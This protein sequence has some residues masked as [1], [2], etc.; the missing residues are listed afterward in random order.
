MNERI[1]NGEKQGSQDSESSHSI[2][3]PKLE[4]PKG[5]GAIKGID[6]KFTVN[7][8]NGSSSFSIP[9][10]FSPAR[11]NF[12]PSLSASYNSGTGNSILGIGWSMETTSIQRKTD[13]QLPSYSEED[14]FMISGTEDL[15]PYFEWNGIKWMPVEET[16]GDFRIKRF[17]PRIEG[18]FSRI[19]KIIHPVIGTF[20]RTCN[21]NNTTTFFGY[22]KEARIHDPS[23]ETKI[24]QWLPEFSFDDKGNCIAFEYKKENTDKITNSLHEKN[25]LNGTALFLNCYLKRVRH[26]NRVPYYVDPLAPYSLNVGAGEFVFETVFDFGEHDPDFPLPGEIPAL[27]WDERPDAFSSY[28]SGFEIRTYRLLKRVLFYH[29]FDELNSGVSTLVRSVDFAYVLSSADAS[30]PTELSCLQSVTHCG[31][32]LK[33]DQ[34]Y[35]KKTLPPVEF[36]YEKLNWSNTVKELSQTSMENLPYGIGG[37]YQWMDFFGEGISGV[38]TEQ[39]NGWFYKSNL[40]DLEETGIVT[41]DRLQ[42]ISPKPS[43]SGMNSGTLV[44]QDIEAD[45]RKQIVI[46]NKD[47]N[48]YFELSEENEWGLFRNFETHL[49]IDLHDPNVRA[50]DLTGDGKPDLLITEHDVFTIHISKGKAGYSASHKTVKAFDEEK[51]P[52]IVFSDQK[53]SIY[54]ADLSGDGLTDIVRIRNGEVCYWPNLGYGKFGAKISM[55]NAPV[56]DH[57]DQF[58]PL[59]LQLADVSGTGATDILY[60]GQNKCCAYINLAGNAW[61]DEQN[62]SGAFRTALPDKITVVDLSGNGTACIVWSSELPGNVNAPLL[63]IDLMSGKKPHLMTRHINNLGKE[64]EIEY[65]SSTWFYLKDKSEQ[66]PWITKLP[67]PVHCVRKQKITDKITGITFTNSYRYHH[68]YYD[69]AEREFRGFGMV[70][71]T[72]TEEYEHWIKSGAGN[73]VPADLH[74][75]PVLTK[76]WFHTGAFLD[77]EKILTQFSRE[78]WYEEMIRKGFPVTSHEVMLPDAKLKAAVNLNPSILDSL[79]TQEWREAF[80]ACKGMILRQ[81]IFSLDAPVAGATPAQLQLELSPYSVTTH[82]CHI[83]LQQPLTTNRFAVFT[84]K[85]SE[86]ITY[87]YERDPSD[88]RIAHSL[89]IAFDEIGNVLEAASVVYPRKIADP[90]LPP[91]I[92]QKQQKTFITYSENIYTND[93]TDKHQYRLRQVSENKTYELKGVPKMKPLY[94]VNDFT[95]IVIAATELLYQQFNVDPAPGTSS[96]RLIKHLRNIFYTNDLSGALPL[97]TLESHA[98]PFETYQKAYTPELVSNIFGAKVNDALLL[99]GK[100]THSEG[101]LNWWIRSGTVQ[102]LNPSETET[103]ARNHFYMPVSF[104]EPFGGITK[105][106]YLFNYFMFIKETEDALLNKNSVVVFNF[107]TLSPQRIKDINNN[108]IEALSDELS[109]VK[110]TAFFG[111]GNEADDLSGHTEYSSPADEQIASDLF[112]AS[113]SDQLILNG[114]ALLK[115]ATGYF[116]YDMFRYKNSFGKL[117]TVMLSIVRE[118]HFVLNNDSP[119]QLSFEY[120]N[121]MGGV[122]MKKT[123]CEPGPAKNVIVNPDDTIVISDINTSLLVPKQLR[124]LGNGRTVLNNKGKPVKQYE[125]Y[126]S[127]T[128]EYED[129]KELVETGVTPVLYY[130]SAGRLIRT[131]FPN[132]TFSKTEF[133]SWK[134]LVFDPNDTILESSWYTNRINH[135][136]DAE[137]I[138]E[139]KDPVKEK[140]AAEQ[141]AL[142]ANTPTTQYFD[143]LG[144]PMFFV[145]H[146]GKDAQNNELLYYSRHETDIEGN[147]KSIIDARDN[148]VILYSHDMLSHIVYQESMDAGKRWLFQNILANPLRTWDQRNHEFI[149]YYDILHRCIGKRVMG[150]DSAIPL[151]HLIEKIIFGE[152]IPDAAQFN[153]RGKPVIIY[154]TAG[155]AETIAYDFKGNIL[156]STRT[157][158]EQYKEVVNWDSV[159]PD[160][161]L[162]LVSHNS[163]TSFDALGRIFSQNAAD[164]SVLTPKYNESGKLDSIEVTQGIVKE[165]F[166]KNITYNEKGQRK[167]IIYGNN[168]L[169]SYFYDKETFALI[170]LET[171]KQNNDPLQDFYYTFDPVGNITHLEDKNIPDVFFNNQKITGIANYTYDPLYRLSKA[172][173]REH[174]AQTNFGLQDNWNDLSFLKQYSPNDPMAWRKYTQHY[175]Y[176]DAGNIAQMKHIAVNGNWTRDYNYSA[177]SN[178]L[179]STVAGDDNNIYAP[180]LYPHHAEHG[181][182]AAMPHLQVMKWNFMEELQAVAKQKVVNGTPETTYYVYD[183]HGQ[184]TR[185][186]TEWEDLLNTGNPPKKSER[187]YSGP[188]EFYTEYDIA[189]VEQLKRSTYHVMD[190][191]SRIAMIERKTFGI[192]D[193]PDRLVRYQFS[194]H[195]GSAS[196]ET[197]QDA[198]IISYE[199]FHPFGTTAYQAIDKNIKAAYKQYR[200]TGMERDDESGLEY[201][202]ARY[203]LPW[204][205]RWLNADPIGI[206][207]GQ[208]LYAYAHNCPINF[209]DKTGHQPK[210]KKT[211]AEIEAERVKKEIEHE[212]KER[213]KQKKEDE[214]ALARIRA[215]KTIQDAIDDAAQ[216]TGIDEESLEMLIIIESRGKMNANAGSFYGLTQ[217]GETAFKAVR[218]GSTT[219][220]DF[221]SLEVID[222]TTQ[223]PRAVTWDDVKTDPWAN[224]MVGALYAQLHLE[225]I[226]KYNANN[227]TAKAALAKKVADLEK[228]GKHAQAEKLK[229]KTKLNTDIPESTLSLYMMHQQGGHG[230]KQILNHPGSTVEK[231]QTG[232]LSDFDKTRFK[233]EGAGKKITKAEFMEAWQER[234]DRLKGIFAANPRP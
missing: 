145:E 204:L 115:H 48:G 72:D 182:I 201:H 56:F 78:Y 170:R 90:D 146:N 109:I 180:Y 32:V 124:W 169:A 121:G 41:L 14:V 25:R 68:G 30:Q 198:K 82:N 99:E 66:K 217:M 10:P 54:L 132:G 229:K 112:A 127:I 123:Q 154:D 160:S 116:A 221:D 174:A 73:I 173:G 13:K 189:G 107:R 60:L 50:L 218:D 219:K 162:E 110:A 38:F 164:G 148:T 81:E 155:K 196:L 83:E 191:K 165:W 18:T 186:I 225:E 232:N 85:E 40:G 8:S 103:D 140:E 104:T 43:F 133:D 143:T 212:D 117:P 80:R 6:E 36:T 183:A 203:Y 101:D 44:M 61:S 105:V 95:G 28:R 158:A 230:Y 214:D 142:H 205:G 26:G 208:N 147:T 234:F 37:N 228:D 190:D 171:K 211:K 84:V 120:S 11:N 216:M 77:K 187:I 15:V 150:G 70:E 181:F 34:T 31:Y 156:Q 226:R 213:D 126:F 20:W 47:I 141:T 102:Y 159:D 19:E 176:D 45:G 138:A 135:L 1:N 177:T 55:S 128:R 58:N 157:F 46:N 175:T 134:Q 118:Q 202:N 151:N 139:G 125:P 9:L 227:A 49:T 52:A 178:R 62:I 137:L 209:I 16:F 79:S 22:H 5:G 23:D 152:D 223:L 130:D 69:H 39:G 87:N 161:K 4:L 71:Q 63:Y 168:V 59:Y 94:S 2:T 64:T 197:D 215:D 88:P 27:K 93:V 192:A 172:T 167:K 188:V 21:P 97:H 199:E 51:G 98:I 53:Q 86:A 24:F 195:L 42:K 12:S 136:I 74:Q 193:E 33:P 207:G 7:P 119:I 131:E 96:K 179:S 108:F 67:F 91:D 35:S 184:R 111:K 106:K 76:T 163:A 224:I 57:P 149:F 29:K 222:Q 166:V 220:T 65:K 210:P 3:V 144:R 89:N 194:N 185:K 129:Y 231:N 114:K 233:R 100:F 122:V 92:Q 17:R 113:T 75:P 206:A 153:F 200:Y